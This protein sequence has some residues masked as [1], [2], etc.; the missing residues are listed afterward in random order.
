MP[1]KLFNVFMGVFLDQMNNYRI[2]Q[3]TLPYAFSIKNAVVPVLHTNNL[4][5]GKYS[6][7]PQNK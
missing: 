5:C 3:G 1:H 2:I 4:K 6:S 7:K